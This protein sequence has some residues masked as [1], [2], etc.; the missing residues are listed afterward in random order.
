MRTRLVTAV[1]LLL[2]VGCFSS[3]IAPGAMAQVVYGQPT[4]AGTRVVFTDW[5]L[6]RD[7]FETSLSQFYIPISGFVPLR[8][9]FELTFYA[10][11]AGNT[12]EVDT[13]SSDLNGLSDIRLKANHSFANDQLLLS[14]GLNLP[15]GK[16]ELAFEDEFL[17]LQTM[18][19]N[20]LD[21]PMR[22][23]GEGF[24]FSVL[25]GGATVLGRNLRGG[26]S[27]MY[28]YLGEYTP[29]ESSVDYDPGDLISFN[30]GLD[31]EQGAWLWS[32]E[33][34]YTIYT[35]DKY[36]G[37]KNFRQ[38]PQTDLRFRSSRSSERSSLDLMLRYVARGDNKEYNQE[39]EEVDPFRLYGNEFHLHGSLTL[40]L[41]ETFSAGPVLQ[42]RSV[43]DNAVEGTSRTAIGDASVF[44]FGAGFGLDLS[45]SLMLDGAAKFFSGSADGGDSDLSGYQIAVGLTAAM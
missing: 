35:D 21:I 14:V 4:A 20:F 24:G 28:E 30:A 45:S 10:A 1:I 31:L 40:A 41:S 17:V 29:Y 25:F 42:F 12:L 33:G 38:S 5:T 37:T 11:N 39:G 26:G 44:G 36:D 3:V 34:V 2:V 13:I 15:T 22:R 9:N 23:L 32:V 19:V 6:E 7:G 16:T 18:S 8:D 27:I 43:G